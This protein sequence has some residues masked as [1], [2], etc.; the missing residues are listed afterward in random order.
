MGRHAVA[1]VGTPGV[2]DRGAGIGMN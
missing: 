1:D 2:S